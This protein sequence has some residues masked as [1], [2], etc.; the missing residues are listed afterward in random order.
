M[1][2]IFQNIGKAGQGVGDVLRGIGGLAGSVGGGYR[3]AFYGIDRKQ[4]QQ[5][6]ELDNGLKRL[7]MIYQS[8]DYPA[9]IAY[10]K[11]LMQTFPEL[12]QFAQSQGQGQPQGAMSNI[13]PEE[14]KSSIF[15]LAR[16]DIPQS[17]DAYQKGLEG[18]Y[19]KDREIG[20]PVQPQPQ[21]GGA[22]AGLYGPNM[23]MQAGP[24]GIERVPMS[25][26]QYNAKTLSGASP[27]QQLQSAGAFPSTYAGQDVMSDFAG[28]PMGPLQTQ[29]LGRE[30]QTTQADIGSKKASR[31]SSLASAAESQA[32]TT[33]IPLA[34]QQAGQTAQLAQ[35][36]AFL[37][38]Q[39]K[40]R[41]FAESQIPTNPLG[42]LTRQAY[43]DLKSHKINNDQYADRLIEAAEKAR[44]QTI[45]NIDNRPVPTSTIE[46]IAGF[47][48]LSREAKK[49]LKLAQPNFTG[50]GDS[51]SWKLWLED[52]IVGNPQGKQSFKNALAD[53]K[54]YVY[55]LTG[56][57]FNT[58]DI[59]ILAGLIPDITMNDREFVDKLTNFV[60]LLDNRHDTLLEA[61]NQANY[62]TGGLQGRSQQGQTPQPATPSRADRMRAELQKREGQ[63]NAPA[64]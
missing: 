30:Q 58:T 33:D 39:N 17:Y 50:L 53:L 32:R 61:L 19:A 7:K 16:Q 20:P 37:A 51:N 35:E 6:V 59:G 57:A 28:D 45:T 4:E 49:A 63:T 62:N 48:D 38:Q 22:L 11:Q 9:A 3:D 8:G 60:D 64:K 54:T 41:E 43:E 55:N 23:T 29:R 24:S 42:G 18:L 27:A 5:S 1:A 10:T 40:D 46:K 13:N 12:Q 44:P 34:R 47:R 31:R 26:T 36:Q 25:Q 14:T 52:N 56:A 2:D 15:G 21:Q